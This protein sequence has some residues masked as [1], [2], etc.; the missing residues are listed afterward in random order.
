MIYHPKRKSKD[1]PQAKS[2]LIVDVQRSI[3]S[4]QDEALI[5]ASRQ[6]PEDYLDKLEQVEIAVRPF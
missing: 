4:S 6:I 2:E 3:C 5:L 1:D